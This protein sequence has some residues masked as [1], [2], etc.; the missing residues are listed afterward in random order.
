M[1]YVTNTGSSAVSVID[2]DTNNL[3][4]GLTLKIVPSNSGKI[5]CED[6]QGKNKGT[7]YNNDQYIRIDFGKKVECTPSPYIGN[8]FSI[9]VD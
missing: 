5:E 1:I 8:T 2:G 7:M 4:V 6:V 9:L 3:V